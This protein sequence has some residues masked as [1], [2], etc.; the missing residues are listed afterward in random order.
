[1]KIIAFIAYRVLIGAPRANSSAWNY[2]EFPE[3]GVIYKCTIQDS[4]CDTVDIDTSGNK[5]YYDRN[6][7]SLENKMSSWLGASMDGDENENDL[8]VVK[9]HWMRSA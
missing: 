9:L 8:I 6:Y 2:Q 3:I 5:Y 7:D 4:N 1:M